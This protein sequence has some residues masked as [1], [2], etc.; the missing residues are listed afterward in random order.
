VGDQWGS[1]DPADLAFVGEIAV[2]PITARAGFID[3]DKVLAFGPQPTDEFIDVALA[4]TDVTKGD[5]LGVAV[6]GDVGDGNRVFMD[7]ETDVECA[8]RWHG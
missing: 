5:D 3:K 6:L 7:I 8:R 4:G 1:D 2:E